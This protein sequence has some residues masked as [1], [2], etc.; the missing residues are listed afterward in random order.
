MTTPKSCCGDMQQDSSVTSFDRIKRLLDKY[1]QYR[2]SLCIE[3]AITYT[4]VYKET[5]GK[6][7]II[8]RAMAFKRYCEEREINILDDELIVGGGASKPRAAIFC[9]E[10]ASSWLEEENP[11][12]SG[13]YKIRYWDKNWQQII[14]GNPDAYLDKILKAGFDGV[15]LDLVDSYEYFEELK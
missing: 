6:S 9:P 2:P 10:H 11:D 3:R 12:W 8:R 5:E 15:Y 1:F 14:F 4:D 13:N 7:A